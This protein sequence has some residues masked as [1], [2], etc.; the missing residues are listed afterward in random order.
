MNT[1]KLNGIEVL[2][3]ISKI[4]K[5]IF[6]NDCHK[7]AYSYKIL[8]KHALR[9]NDPN[10]I[11]KVFLLNA[12]VRR[13]RT[14]VDHVIHTFGNCIPQELYMTCGYV[15]RILN[16]KND[17][18]PFFKKI[19]NDN[20]T[21]ENIKNLI[22][23]TSVPDRFAEA[24]LLCQDILKE[25]PDDL[26]TLFLL[27]RLLLYYERIE[28]GYRYL[29]KAL[30]INPDHYLIIIS[31]A[32]YNYC[33]ME[34]KNALKLYKKALKE[35]G[36]YKLLAYISECYLFQRKYRKAKSIANNSLQI[37]ED[38]RA[39]K[40]INAIE[41][42]GSPGVVDFDYTICAETFGYLSF[43][44]LTIDSGLLAYLY[45][46][47]MLTIRENDL[48]HI[49]EAIADIEKE[50][51][52]PLLSKE[53]L[54]SVLGRVKFILGHKKEGLSDMRL[55]CDIKTTIV[56]LSNLIQCLTLYTHERSEIDG[57][58]Q[59]LLRLLIAGEYEY[60]DYTSFLTCEVTPKFANEWFEFYKK[61]EEDLNDWERFHYN[62]GKCHSCRQDYSAALESFQ[63]AREKTKKN[64]VYI[65]LAQAEC[66]L[67]QEN[68]ESAKKYIEQ[69]LIEY[70]KS[71]KAQQMKNKWW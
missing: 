35:C 70:P 4:R 1:I 60:S 56:T 48:K 57:L 69:A 18:L 67:A 15:Y 30:D 6:P 16:L 19:Y 8:L 17:A 50:T 54:P 61:K 71:E 10:C 29:K 24:Y 23:V 3:S 14:Y 62:L 21:I 25:Y 9:D 41:N 2:K 51:K 12:C 58:T 46:G 66:F 55:A 63:V 52:E 40:V 27:S 32:D 26:E 47:A 34:Y 33:C 7:W 68:I 39:I 59:R 20:P 38:R 5:E 44:V 28:D 64:P 42:T 65:T 13:D 45:Y 49:N 43:E 22:Y 11:M 31:H 36:D 37:N 53:Y